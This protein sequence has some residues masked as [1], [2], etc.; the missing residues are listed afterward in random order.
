MNRSLMWLCTVLTLG[1]LAACAHQDGGVSPGS[2]TASSL[3]AYHWQLGKALDGS[4][5]AQPQWAGPGDKAVTLTFK[6]QRLSVT[7]L[8]NAMGASYR[9]TGTQ[10]HISQVTSTMR[11]CS[12][13]ALMKYEQAI[14]TRLPEVS[15]WSIEDAQPGP[16]L[17]LRFEDGGQWLL[18]GEPTAETQ[19]GSAGEIMFLEIAPQEIPCSHPLIPNKQ[20]LNVRTVQYDAAGIKQGHGPWQPL[21]ENIDGYQHEPGVRNVLRVKRYTRKDVPADASRHA[22]VLDMTVETELPGASN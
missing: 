4:G 10:I 22:Y 9:T 3:S 21:Y 14:G 8:C 15:A 18:E 11:M 2:E 16:T 12:D 1:G 5:N 6:D 13:T 7:G 20:C 19:Y 17:T